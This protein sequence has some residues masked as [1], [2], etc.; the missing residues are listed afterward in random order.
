MS[1]TVAALYHF[2]RLEDPAALRAPLLALC[3]AQ[4]VRGTL[5]L[6]REGI[7]GTIAGPR[8][9]IDAVLAR[10]RALPGCAAL[11]V[12]FSSAD[13]MPFHRTKVRLK[14]EIV[15]MGMPDIDPTDPGTYVAPADWNALI[16]DPATLVI[17]TRNDYEVAVGTFAGAVDPGTVSFRDFPTWFRD[18]RDALLA[19]KAR[20]AMFCTGGIRCEKATA[21]LKAEGVEDVF[22]L[23]GGILKYLEETPVEDSRWQGECFVFDERVAVG[24]GLEPGSHSLCRGCRMPVSEADRASPLYVE[25]VSCPHCHATRDAETKARAAERHRQVELA[26]KRGAAHVGA[27]YP[28]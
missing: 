13:A 19:G 28:D 15:T 2:T 7:N 12:K 9:G 1:V 4:G 6:A 17:D 8:A 10:I 25:G 24:H 18:H 23:K 5:L 22:H 16:T 27:R 3:E 26:A 11:D 14:R 21:F 20:V